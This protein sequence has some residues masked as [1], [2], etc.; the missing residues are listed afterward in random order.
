[1]KTPPI[2]RQPGGGIGHVS[3]ATVRQRQGR[4]DAALADITEHLRLRPDDPMAYLFRS[5]LHKE[6]KALAS[7]LEDLNAAHRAAPDDPQVCNNLAWMLATCADAQLRDGSR[8]VALARQACRATEWKHPFCLGTLG[9]ALAETG[10]F[11]EAIRWQTEALALYPE[12]EKAA[13]R[14]RLELYR[15]AQPY[16]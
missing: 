7:A 4:L 13:G 12:S 14:E 3:R 11:D 5:G 10:A 9:A 15:D 8:A 6:R 16:R 2:D 1:D